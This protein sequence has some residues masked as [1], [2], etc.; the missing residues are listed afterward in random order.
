MARAR[1][2]RLQREEFWLALVDNKN[3]LF[4]FVQ[5]SF[6]TVD[7]T[8]VYPREVMRLAIS[9]QASGIVLVHN[10]PGG[11]PRPSAQ[12]KELTGRIRSAATELGIR[13]LD[14]VIVC[15]EGFFSFQT[16]N[17]L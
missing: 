5:L 14:H 8:A 4:D 16:S 6:G 17:L 9:R 3:R 2:G 12:D 15:E 11:D 13:V 1:L 10:H 7:Q